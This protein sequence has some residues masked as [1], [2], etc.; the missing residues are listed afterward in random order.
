MEEIRVGPLREIIDVVRSIV[1]DWDG[2]IRQV[3]QLTREHDDTAQALSELRSAHDALQREHADT[4]GA[5][6]ELRERYEALER[7]RLDAADELEALLRR[8]K[9]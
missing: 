7:H 2:F 4:L 8:L 9:P 3:D 1:T 5:H 6:H